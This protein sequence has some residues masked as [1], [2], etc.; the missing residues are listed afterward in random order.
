SMVKGLG[1]YDQ[2]VDR[3]ILPRLHDTFASNPQLYEAIEKVF[4]FV[5][6]TNATSLGAFGAIVM[7]YTSVG[8]VGNVA[9]GLNALWSAPAPPFLRRIRDYITIVVL[10]PILLTVGGSLIAAATASSATNWVSHRLGF[11]FDVGLAIGPLL[12]AFIGLFVMYMTLPNQHV[13]VPSAAGGAAVGRPALVER[14][15]PLP[16]LPRGRPPSHAP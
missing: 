16:A 8:L 6:G 1:A 11:L 2:L 10:A 14:R 4:A 15:V 13:R 5:S 9:S 12:V 3:V 7:A